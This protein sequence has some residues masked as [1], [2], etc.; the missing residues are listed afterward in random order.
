MPI[1]CDRPMINCAAAGDIASGVYAVHLVNNGAS[2]ETTL[3]GLPANLKVLRIYVTDARRG[4]KEG[5][6]IPVTN[7]S[8]QFMLEGGTFTTLIGAI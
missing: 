4:M 5:H 2:R 7:G 1:T 3:T 6:R 8:A